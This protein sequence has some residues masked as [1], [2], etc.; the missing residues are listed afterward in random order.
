MKE[1]VKL[2]E[3]VRQLKEERA[4]QETHAQAQYQEEVA[5]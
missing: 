4:R 2:R 5:E 3:Q 1:N